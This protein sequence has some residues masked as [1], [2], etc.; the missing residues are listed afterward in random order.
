M[1]TTNIILRFN[2]LFKVLPT[3][4]VTDHVKITFLKEMF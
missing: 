4:H 1:I 3:G 2:V